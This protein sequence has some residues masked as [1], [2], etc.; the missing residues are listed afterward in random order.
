M[1]VTG[2]L[3]FEVRVLFHHLWNVGKHILARVAPELFDASQT[4]VTF[5][6]RS[7]KHSEAT[8]LG[9][10]AP[11]LGSYLQPVLKCYGFLG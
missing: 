10:I 1:F 9:A 3:P 8:R 4:R 2:A 6:R 5:V 7:F 11:Q